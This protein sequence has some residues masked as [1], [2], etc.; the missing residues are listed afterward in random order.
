[1]STPFETDSKTIILGINNFKELE[2]NEIYP[3]RDGVGSLCIN[4]DFCTYSD[5]Y[6]TA[7][8]YKEV[9]I[10]RTFWE[11]LNGCKRK[12]KTVTE[13]IIPGTYVCSNPE[14]AQYKGC[15]VGHLG[16][17]HASQLNVMPEWK[18]EITLKGSWSRANL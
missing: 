17:V 2:M 7:E 14:S 16:C 3:D 5:V 12:Y 6:N 1:M 18:K 15:V 4:C 10:R 13:V 9:P 8:Y 11:L